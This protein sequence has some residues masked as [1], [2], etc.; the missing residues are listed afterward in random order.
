MSDAPDDQSRAASIDPGLRRLLDRQEISDVIVRLARATDRCDAELMASC[1]HPDATDDHGDFVG[2]AADFV[3][4]VMR[5]L[6][7]VTLTTHTVCNVLVE[8]DGDTAAAESR[9]LAFARSDGARGRTDSVGAGRYLD[10]LERR[11]GEWRI[12]HREAVYD[13]NSTGPAGHDVYEAAEHLLVG[14]R[15]RGDRSYAFLPARAD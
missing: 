11:A 6:E 3:P 15:G 4:W 1:F 2:T 9:F 7:H 8:F 12:S 10:R 5:V 13:W 14:R